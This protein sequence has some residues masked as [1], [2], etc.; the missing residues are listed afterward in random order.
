MKLIILAIDGVINQR[1]DSAITTAQQCLPFPDSLEAIAQLYRHGY[2]IIVVSNQPGIAAGLLTIQ[3]LNDIHDKLEQQ[4]SL[5]GAQLEAVM[6]CPHA[7]DEHCDCR[8]PRPGLLLDLQQRM[9]KSLADVP[10]VVSTD[11]EYQAALAV[12]AAVVLIRDTMETVED[13]EAETAV[14]V[15]SSLAAFTEH[16]LQEQ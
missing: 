1:T 16:L 12:N 14:P 5:L 3:A 2:R 6:F 7:E 11:A 10:M 15:Y 13:I 9:N 4:L 8:M